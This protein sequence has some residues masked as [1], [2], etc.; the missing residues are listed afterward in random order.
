M[1]LAKSKG[2][3]I[4]ARK[5]ENF[6]IANSFLKKSYLQNDEIKALLTEFEEAL[7][8]N[9]KVRQELSAIRVELERLQFESSLFNQVIHVSADE[10]N[11]ATMM[12]ESVTA[13][14]G[15]IVQIEKL[16]HQVGMK[17]ILHYAVITKEEQT[18]REINAIKEA[19][20]KESKQLDALESRSAVKKFRQLQIT[21][22][23]SQNNLAVLQQEVDNM[24]R[25]M[26]NKMKKAT[27]Y[28]NQK[29]VHILQTRKLIIQLE[30]KSPGLA[31][32]Q[33]RLDLNRIKRPS[34]TPIGSPAISILQPALDFLSKFMHTSDDDTNS[35]PENDADR[36]ISAPS[37]SKHVRFVPSPDLE[38]I[39]IVDRLSSMSTDDDSVERADPKP[40]SGNG[41]KKLRQMTED[42][43]NSMEFKDCEE[44]EL[45]SEDD[46]EE[47]QGDEDLEMDSDEQESSSDDKSDAE[48]DFKADEAQG[49]EDLK[50]DSDEQESSSDDKSDAEGTKKNG[51]TQPKMVLQ[52]EE[53]EKEDESDGSWDEKD[54]ESQSVNNSK[55]E[56][57]PSGATAKF[58][59]TPE[60]SAS[61]YSRF[62]LTASQKISHDA[63]DVD[64]QEASDE[65]EIFA[66]PMAQP[67]PTQSKRQDSESPRSSD[68]AD[69]ML[70]FSEPNCE[71][72]DD[73]WPT[74]HTNAGQFYNL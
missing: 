17:N 50:M 25:Q 8:G 71:F 33:P 52:W 53:S 22:K 46:A 60:D 32:S 59:F 44:L 21:L 13:C 7:D 28:R 12:Y 57:T 70:N 40:D 16:F 24:E 37:P 49:D 43:Q 42:V 51:S 11:T 65:N 67:K 39:H 54:K 26:R 38:S 47:A 64:C 31:G 29:I 34:T 5:M 6:P 66:I 20:A 27:D 14:Y 2:L 30:S 73:F 36:R 74:K 48:V 41:S 62:K 1:Q 35:D 58:T 9:R 61:K 23:S 45:E 15:K 68:R 55:V 56:A 63:M 69:S 10:K 4:G 18:R 72:N 3:A 19:F